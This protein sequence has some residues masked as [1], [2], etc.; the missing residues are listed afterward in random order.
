M[1]KQRLG[2]DTVMYLMRSCDITWTQREALLVLWNRIKT[3][4]PQLAADLDH[5]MGCLVV[6]AI[7]S[8]FAAGYELARNPEPVLFAAGFVRE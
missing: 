5:E 8:G 3:I 7:Q 2:H 1:P 4:D 6:D